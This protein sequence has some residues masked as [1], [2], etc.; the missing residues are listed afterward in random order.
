MRI[1]EHLAEQ[2]VSFESLLHPPAF[3]AQKLAKV[4]RVRGSEV[5]K[6]VLLHGP[7]GYFLAVLP[8]THQ[9]DLVV[10]A[11]HQGGGVYLATTE[12][13]AAVFLDCEWGSVSPFGNLYGVPTLLDAGITPEMWIVVE[14]GSHVEAVRLSCRDFERLAGSLRVAFARK[15]L[16]T[17]G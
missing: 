17:E 10:L 12:E 14:A 1:A 15:N 13:V 16:D 9:V 6:A 4:L 5:A 2:Q 7:G 3:S 8:A 11:E